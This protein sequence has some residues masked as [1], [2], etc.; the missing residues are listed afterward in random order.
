MES[1]GNRLA[2]FQANRCRAR[3][4]LSYLRELPLELCEPHLILRHQGAA[5]AGPSGHCIIND[6]GRTAL[7]Q[8]KEQAMTR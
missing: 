7:A 6:V 2:D 1:V 5:E 8:C 3:P 4:R